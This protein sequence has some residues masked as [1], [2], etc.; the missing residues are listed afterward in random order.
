MAVMIKCK[1]CGGDLLLVEGSTIAT[2]E[3][4]GSTQ[5]VPS[6][7]N[8]KK[9]T[10]FSRADRLRRSCE[11]DKAAGI[12]E[13]IVADFPEES[14]AY[15]GLVLCKYGIEYVDDPATGKKIPTCH[16][17]SFDSIFD[18]ANFEQTLENAD[19]ASRK[20]Y[21]DEAKEIEELRKGIIEVSNKEE[22][23]D[24]FICYK[25]TADDGQR[26]L[27][28]VLAQD[29]YDALTEK[30]Y[31]VFFARI[32]LEDKLGQEYEPYI[33]AALNSAKVMLAIG[34]DYEYF[35]A[36]WVKNEW[37]R[38]LKLMETDKNKHLIP[39]YKGIDAYDMPKEFSKLQAQDLGKV[40]ATQDLLRGIDKL[41][42]AKT[43][44]SAAPAAGG[45]IVAETLEK[46][47][48][49]LNA[50]DWDSAG[51]TLDTVR[52]YEPNNVSMLIGK[53]M[54]DCKVPRE[55]LLA[56]C[57][58]PLDSNSNYQQALRFAD[59]DTKKRLE[60]Y[61]KTIIYHLAL[62][63]A[64]KN[65]LEAV[66]AALKSLEQIAGFQDTDDQIL[67]LQSIQKKLQSK[68][69]KGVLIAVA[70]VLLAVL[71][72]GFMVF[73]K[74]YLDPMSIYKDA[75]A[76]MD[77]GDFT[78]AEAKFLE[79][80]NF[81]DNNTKVLECRY[82]YAEKLMDAKQYQN[83]A[84]IFV[85]ISDFSDSA[86]RA[87]ECR[88]LHAERLMNSDQPENAVAVF[89][90]LG[91]YSDSATRVLECYYKMGENYWENGNLSQ[92]QD[93]FGKAGSYLDAPARKTEAANEEAYR[94]ATNKFSKSAWSNAAAIFKTIMDSKDSKSLYCQACFTIAE[95]KT[96]TNDL[97]TAMRIFKE[98]LQLDHA[99][100]TAKI[101]NILE[102]IYTEAD[103]LQVQKKYASA[104]N[105]FSYLAQVNYKDSNSRQSSL[106]K[107]IAADEAAFEGI[108]YSTDAWFAGAILWIDNGKWA[109][110]S[111]RTASA[112]DDYVTGK[113]AG[114][115]FTYDPDTQTVTLRT[116]KHANG[117]KD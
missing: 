13:N 31:R 82:L 46:A 111:G 112:V 81:Q 8:E 101:N 41:I 78:G 58:A 63:S 69:K 45:N 91:K 105:L 100:T 57:S 54:R 18:N 50:Q 65:T 70:A 89:E 47:Y 40:G 35:N 88:Y 72:A 16:R 42:G 32:T 93:A 24:I 77:A 21:R 19:S 59:P 76:L 48:G 67:K 14:E 36:V 53:L 9:L 74:N 33:F 17:S 62:N 116:T 7:D 85:D 26:T 71:A 38:Y 97:E 84:D 61:N 6:Q 20:L 75:L 104:K 22:P 66:T 52:G 27:D 108:W 64:K 80:D 110:N 87:L 30:K 117:E 95:N 12:Y 39:C 60:T 99:E 103:E 15:W 86:A 2:C 5:T 1:M 25:E 109:W 98:L 96:S 92:A 51:F 29:L 73:K 107:Q 106:S 102:N 11:F 3:F 23:Y 113:Y 56:E 55:A 43:A 10:L 44:Q 90:S 79:L 34:S 49:F 114:S 68:K 28:S 4:C 83:A 115:S 94:E 37:S